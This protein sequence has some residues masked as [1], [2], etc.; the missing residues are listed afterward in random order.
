MSSNPLF[1][2]RIKRILLPTDGSV[3][4]SRAANVAI[5][6]AKRFGAELVV[7]HV[8]AVPA[9]RVA[10][11]ELHPSYDDDLK[12]Y[13]A[14]A[15]KKADSIV[16]EVTRLAEAKDV[17]TTHLIQEYSFSVVETILDQ[18][19]KSN[20]DLIVMGT[21]GLTGFKKLLVGSISSGVV[22]HAHCSVLIVR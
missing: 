14:S 16:D 11:A 15:R 4:G 18:A 8:I 7:L 17:K 20:V 1:E 3:G 9:G 13:F 2:T 21:R 19:V 10:K 6:V 5:E 12:E 22:S